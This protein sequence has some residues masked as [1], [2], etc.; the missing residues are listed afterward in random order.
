MSI[1]V[2]SFDNLTQ[3]QVNQA[4]DLIVQMV[5]EHD[6]TVDV[7]RGAIRDLVLYL[8]GV[9]SAAN[10]ANIDLV[11]QSNSVLA[12]NQ[13]P[14]LSDTDLVDR[15]ASNYRL[16]RSTGTTASGSVTIILSANKSIVVPAGSVFTTSSGLLFSADNTY[17]S[18]TSS[19]DVVTTT[20]RLLVSLGNG[21]YAFTIN[22]LANAVGTAYNIARNTTL[23]YPLLDISIV[24]S[25]TGSDFVGGTD[26]ETNQELITR[27]QSGLVYKSL[28]NRGCIEG[29]IR[30]LDLSMYDNS[31][32]VSVVGYGDQ[33]QQRYHS[34]LPVAFGGRVDVYARTQSIAQTQENYGTATYI[35]VDGSGHG[36]W[37]LSLNRD[38]A[39]GVYELTRITLPVNLSNNSVSSFSILSDVRGYDLTVG[40][41]AGTSYLPD[42]AAVSE[43]VYSRY[44]TMVVTFVDTTTSTG[45][46]TA[47]VSQQSYGYISSSMPGISA[48][49]DAVSD[50]STRSVVS[51]CL[52][53][54]A[55]PCFVTATI[56]I[57]KK[58]SAT[59]PA[60]SDLQQAA[61]DAVNTIGFTGRLPVSAIISSVQGLLSTGMSV[62]SVTV[63]GRVRKPDGTSVIQSSSTVLDVSSL[64][65]TG[66]T[67][68]LTIGFLLSPSNVTISVN[69][70]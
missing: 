22:V 25:Y 48:I 18:R 41:T 20:D 58:A 29:L 3:D 1:N 43:A 38:Q 61:A 7:K 46:L 27:L 13:N 51:D 62:S 42:I 66:M 49:Q 35:G 37:Q 33:E 44:Q 36:K 24:R 67:S 64:D 47:N 65:V 34:I 68:L 21:T 11:R 69:S 12:I 2:Q 52:I 8:S 55:V 17:T 4:Y 5:Q 28:A 23:A 45:G 59:L 6:N 31:F 54:A 14:L 56:V 30:S 26:A 60:T 10:Q 32:S 39:A 63:Q 9:L 57:D 40:S 15:V 16:T 50:R 53:K 70:I 19:I